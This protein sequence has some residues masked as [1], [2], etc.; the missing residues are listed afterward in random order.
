MPKGVYQKTKEH[1]SKLKI[2][3]FQKGQKFTENHK[4]K[5]GISNTK[6]PTKKKERIKESQKKCSR[7]RNRRIRKAVIETLGGKCIRCGII[8]IRVLQ[9]DHISGGGSKERKERGFGQ[10]FHSYVI[11]S[12][13]KGENKYQL[14]CANC[15]WIKRVENQ[16]ARGQ[17]EQDYIIK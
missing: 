17:Y 1:I 11:Q 8:D 15:N 4:R 6:D 10:Q 9:I 16:E 14:L 3:G 2:Y 12:F 7:V 5:I 13:L